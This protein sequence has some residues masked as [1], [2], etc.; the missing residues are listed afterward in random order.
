MEQNPSPEERVRLLGQADLNMLDLSPKALALPATREA[1]IRGFLGQVAALREG[2]NA[3]TEDPA[4][5][6]GKIN[7][8]AGAFQ[9]VFYGRDPAYPPVVTSWNNP[10][11]L[12]KW[13]VE[14][15]GVDEHDGQDDAVRALM[16]AC[17]LD[18][19]RAFS[20]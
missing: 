6:P 3:G 4:G 7:D 20:P 1:L 8:A 19:I 17:S 13:L 18:L 2:Y 5:I 14:N 16:V 10:E 9:D 11:H 15:V 12:G